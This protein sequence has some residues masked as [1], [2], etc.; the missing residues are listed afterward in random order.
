MYY[1]AS[2]YN[3]KGLKLSQ[4]VICIHHAGLQNALHWRPADDFVCVGNWVCGGCSDIHKVIQKDYE[5]YGFTW[6]NV[7]GLARWHEEIHMSISGML[8][9]EEGKGVF[10]AYTSVH[11]MKFEMMMRMQ[12]TVREKCMPVCDG[13]VVDVVRI[14]CT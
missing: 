1:S 3:L 2:F 12:P 13:N 5:Q 6:F 11:C 4:K 14:E 8:W 10:V 9:S 7:G